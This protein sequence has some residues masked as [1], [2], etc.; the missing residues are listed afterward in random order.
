MMIAVLGQMGL[1]PKENQTT[2]RNE[3]HGYASAYQYIIGDRE[4]SSLFEPAA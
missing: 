2:A 3:W 4:L 1:K